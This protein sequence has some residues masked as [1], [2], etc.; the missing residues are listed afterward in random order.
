MRLAPVAVLTCS[1]VIHSIPKY[2]PVRISIDSVLNEI[3]AERYG[4]QGV[5]HAR[6]AW[7]TMSEA[8]REYPFHISVVYTCPVQWGSANPLYPEKT[9]Y[10]ATMWGMPYDHLDGWRGPYPADV[11]AD[12]FAKVAQGWRPG[13]E[14]LQRA[15]NAA[16]EALRE[17][18]AADLRYA[19]AA[20]NHFQ[21][22]ANQSR[23]IAARDALADP[24]AVRSPEQQVALRKQMREA[25]ESEIALAQELYRLVKEDS[26]IGFEPSCQYFYLP[27]DLV[28]KVVNCRWLLGR[29]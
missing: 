18:A 5:S 4:T 13:I 23:F 10:S 28:E 14:A 11:F 15:A 17:T 26:R 22:V 16:P 7:T 1:I 12:Q 24:A 20:A 27:L 21:A 8:F 2:P 9:G 25:V 29:M 3:A 6:R 19:R